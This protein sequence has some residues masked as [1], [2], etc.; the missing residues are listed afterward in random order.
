MFKKTNAT[1]GEYTE[2]STAKFPAPTKPGQDGRSV[3]GPSLV[4]KGELSAEEDL[5]I[6]GRIEGSINHSN[7]ALTVRPKG[8]VKA[9]IRA[10][11]ITVEG[12]VEGDLFGDEKVIIRS[13]ARVRGNIVSPRVKLEEGA[14]IRGS[15]NTT[16]QNASNGASEED[17]IVEI[18]AGVVN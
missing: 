18:G 14:N 12:T 1:D 6:Q 2:S 5:D 8:Y 10:R 9:D 16:E 13:S 17:E 11:M 3:L 7:R 15:I 4:F